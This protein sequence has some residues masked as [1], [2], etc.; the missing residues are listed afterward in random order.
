MTGAVQ[1]P[2]RAG[3][4]VIAVVGLG[5]PSVAF[6]LSHVILERLKVQMPEWLG[7]ILAWTLFLTG[8]LGVFTTAGAVLAAIAGS[9]LAGVSGKS[10][11][12][13][14]ATV[15]GAGGPAG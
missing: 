6:V 5:L 1:Q 3:L 9:L 2:R 4:S 10:K 11:A 15:A 12:L 13:M 8:M 14:W 7:L